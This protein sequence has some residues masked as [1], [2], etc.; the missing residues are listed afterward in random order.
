MSFGSFSVATANDDGLIT[1]Q[2]VVKVDKAGT[3]I[4]K[5]TDSE[6]IRIT[7]LKII[8]EIDG[9][10]FQYIR[11][12]AGTFESYGQLS[13][14]DISEARIVP[15][16]FADCYT[17]DNI[18]GKGLFANSRLSSIMLP[19]F[20]P[21][22][23]EATFRGCKNMTSIYVPSS[24]TSIGD[25]A[26]NDCSGLERVGVADGVVSIGM[27]AFQGCSSLTDFVIPSSVVSIG[28]DA[29]DGCSSLTNIMLPSNLSSI[30]YATFRGCSGLTG[31]VIP[32]GITSI[33]GNVFA[34]CSG[35]EKISVERDNVNYDSRNDCNAIINSESNTLIT[36]CRSTVIP[37]NVTSIG[38]SAF[39]GCS[40][41]T[42]IVIPSN[43]TSIGDYAFVGCSFT[44]V[45]VPSGVTSIGMGAFHSCRNLVEINIPNGVTSIKEGTFV[46][47]NSLASITIPSSVTSIGLGAF[48]CC[49]SLTSISFPQGLTSLGEH[50]FYGCDKLASI[51]VNW[52]TPLPINAN[53]FESIDKKSCVLYVPKGTYDDYRLSTWG[54]CFER[55]VEYEP[56]SVNAVTKI[57]DPTESS[58]YS[59]DGQRLNAPTQGLNI[60]KYS[61]GS[62]KKVVVQ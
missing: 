33:E 17:E 18:I 21:S 19:E 24:V 2:F 44:D 27:G 15:G 58:R 9:S 4:D 23:E 6:R 7:N 53:V 1:E 48:Q 57:V 40:G 60:V 16:G 20:M 45:E 50:C 54:D 51:Y 31:I 3:F 11:D 8:G 47:C 41:L 39:E 10:D 55:I 32:S 30:K 42:H 46:N 22:I 59:V 5:I 34:N 62:V 35:L 56:T 61:D 52:K 43:V 13:F 25:D 36:G 49:S 12:M 14:L 28:A 37:N 26:F 29:F 38:E